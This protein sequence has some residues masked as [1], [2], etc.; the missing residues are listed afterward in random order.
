MKRNSQNRVE[1]Q[2]FLMDVFKQKFVGKFQV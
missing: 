1:T 2:A